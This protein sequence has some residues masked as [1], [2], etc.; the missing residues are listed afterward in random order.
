MVT[1]EIK[2]VSFRHKEDGVIESNVEFSVC[3]MTTIFYED[4]ES[5]VLSVQ[6]IVVF[7]AETSIDEVHRTSEERAREQLA[8]EWG[9]L[10][11]IVVENAVLVDT[12][13]SFT[14]TVKTGRRTVVARPFAVVAESLPDAID[15]ARE[16]TRSIFEEFLAAIEQH[17]TQ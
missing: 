7:D 8:S 9:P 15:K 1:V 14:L 4:S 13:W 2:S 3:G 10:E 12:G 11:S 17:K 16:Q 6:A 5:P